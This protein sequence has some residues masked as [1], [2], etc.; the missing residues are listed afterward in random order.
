MELLDELYSGVPSLGSADIQASFGTTYGTTAA[1]LLLVPGLV[2]LIVEPVLFVLADRY[3]RK[4][5]VVGGLLAMGVA[6]MAAALATNVLALIAAVTLSFLGSGCGVALAQASLVDASPERSEQAL[7][8]WALLG[9]LGDLLAPV[10]LG[11]LALCGLGWRASYVVVGAL[12]LFCALLLLRPAF[13][14]AH[15]DSG[16]E[17]AA[18]SVMDALRT[19]LR[20]KALVRWLAV[21]AL[22]EL[23][24]EIVVVFAALYLRDELGAGPVA[25]AI[26]IGV[27][28]A[29]G[30]LGVAVTERLLTRVSAL[31]LLEVSAVVCASSFVAWL[32]APTLELSALCF[33]VVGATAAPMYPIVSAR[34]YRALPGRSG[35]V[36]AVAHLFTPFTLGAPWLLGVVADAFDTRV[37][38]ALLLIQPLGVLLVSVQERRARGRK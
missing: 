4:G 35:T 37:A 25:R 10:L 26:V 7:A 15:A 29:G 30:L 34:A 38:S 23:L 5:F 11:A 21:A 9:E 33:F 20:R 18:S 6:A 32:F 14:A 8:R 2:A 27:G 12:A 28:I 13:P 22:C 16:G 36:N 1:A 17:E 19:A 31:R 3:P 24:D